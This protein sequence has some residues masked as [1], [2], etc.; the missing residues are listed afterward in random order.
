[1]K[2][3][4]VVFGTGS[5]ANEI[6]RELCQEYEII[7]F[8]DNDP[9]HHKKPFF[10]KTVYA[11]NKLPELP[12]TWDYVVLATCSP[13][14]FHIM[15][16]QLES[17]GI[18][19][20]KIIT[21][22]C[23]FETAARNVFIRDYAAIVEENNIAGSIAEAG[24]FQGDFSAQLN[25]LFPLRKLHMFDTFEGFPQEDLQ[26][27]ERLQLSVP[28]EGRFAITSEALVLSKMAYPEQCVIHKGYFPETA[29]GIE[30]EFAFVM[31]DMDLYKPTL[32]GLKFFAPLMSHGGVIVVHDYFSSHYLGVRQAVTE[33]I[34]DNNSRYVILPI[35]DGLSICVAGF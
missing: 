7:G 11:A 8:I 24:V 2:Q 10:G 35:G 16:Q 29:R 3:K 28:E 27:E 15:T 26:M 21:K 32:S 6:Y 12:L 25:R 4:I 14:V 30:E 5:R 22:Y 1:M 33:F 18:P 31:L 20:S 34:S 23:K 9:Y 19:Q 17:Y 13:E